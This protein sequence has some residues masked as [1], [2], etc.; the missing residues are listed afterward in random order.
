MTKEAYVNINS[1]VTF[2]AHPGWGVLLCV[3]VFVCVCVWQ[4]LTPDVRVR[5]IRFWC[6]L[7]PLIVDLLS[8]QFQT[9]Q[10]RFSLFHIPYSVFRIPPLSPAVSFFWD[11]RHSTPEFPLNS[12]RFHNSLHNNLIFILAFHSVVQLMSGYGFGFALLLLLLLLLLW[13]NKSSCGL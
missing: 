6:F 11:S 7:F 4:P 12:T 10:N 13:H 5:A 8:P 9:M 2:W 3:R 1:F